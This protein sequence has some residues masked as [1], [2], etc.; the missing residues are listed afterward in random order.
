MEFCT[1]VSTPLPL[2]LN[3]CGTG[4]RSLHDATHYRDLVGSLLHLANTVR[5]DIAI[6]VGYL[7]RLMNQPT[8]G[9]WN[10]GRRILRY[11]REKTGLGIV[12]QNNNDGSEIVAYSDSDWAQE[13]PSRKSISGGCLC[14]LVDRSHG[15]LSSRLS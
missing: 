6:A 13:R 4:V 15:D 11:L 10:T 8:E 14:L 2:R 9:L 7:S 1:L 5:P 12:Y 3:L